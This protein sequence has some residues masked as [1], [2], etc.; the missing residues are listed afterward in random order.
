LNLNN[1]QQRWHTTEE[2]VRHA[3]KAFDLAQARYKVGSSSIVELSE[4]QLEFTS[5]QI[6]NTNARYDVLIQEA[7][8]N[9]QV[10][11]FSDTNRLSSVSTQLNPAP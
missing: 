7:N 3:A 5:A 9:Y 11:G 2:L 10:G 4:A 8:L 6:A 1:A